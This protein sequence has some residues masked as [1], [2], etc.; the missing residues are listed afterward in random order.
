M[1]N[2]K[3]VSLIF[4]LVMLLGFLGG[5]IVSGQTVGYTN[6]QTNS[7]T[8][9]S[10][11]GAI[12]N[13]YFYQNNN[14]SN[15]YNTYVY[16]E[17]GTTTN[18]NNQTGNQSIG[19]SGTFTQNIENLISRTT[20]HYRAVT[21]GY[22]G[23][24]YGQDSTFTTIGNNYYNNGSLSVTKQ[25]INLTSGNLNWASSVN[26]QPS[27]ILSFAITVQA[28]GQ[29]M[30][31]VMVSD[32]FS[33]TLIYR[34]NLMVNTNFNYSGNITSGINIGT[35]YA[36]QPVI[37]SYQA[38]VAPAGVFALGATAINNNTTVTSSES[39]IQTSNATVIVNNSLV[40]GASTYSNASSIST[41]LTNNFLTDS[42]FLPL[43]LII[44]GLWF[45]LSG[46][47]YKLT[48]TLKSRIKR[49]A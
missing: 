49:Q 6:V 16:F 1:A 4:I 34:G 39:G 20:Y 11:T 2:I 38:Q 23:T 3:K 8:N 18:Y 47:A 29:D 17:W 43:L 25:V 22:N 42:F 15:S 35:V 19:Y 24:I 14:Y 31:N 28:N 21:Q 41:G 27:D 7:A 9:I 32:I 26:A 37:V 36:G 5:A 10:S 45:Y 44:L 46:T 12:L 40:Y 33:S 48:D 30:H 13:G